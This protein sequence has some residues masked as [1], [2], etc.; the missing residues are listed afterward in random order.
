MFP[1]FSIYLHS[2]TACL[3]LILLFTMLMV[4]DFSNAYSL[5]KITS[6]NIL[7]CMYNILIILITSLLIPMYHRYTCIVIV[8]PY[9]ETFPS[10][11]YDCMN[12][13]TKSLVDKIRMSRFRIC[14]HYTAI[15]QQEA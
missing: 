9:Y 2:L 14:G 15:I 11:W 3:R 13:R 12:K 8:I 6:S 5:I 10:K 1:T 4:N 7:T